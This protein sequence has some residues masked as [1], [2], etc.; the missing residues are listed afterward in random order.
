MICR[1][2]RRSFQRRF[3]RHFSLFWIMLCAFLLPLVVSTYRDSME[4]GARLQL[5][6]ISRGC[7]LHILN[8]APEDLELFRNIDGLTEPFYEDGTIYLSY[9]SEEFWKKST[10]LEILNSMS[11]EE[12][13]DYF[14]EDQRINAALHSAMDKS[15]RNLEI[16]GYAYDMWGEAI[17]YSPDTVAYMRKVLYLNVALVLFS[18]LIVYSAYGNHITGFSQEAAD[19]R[20]LGATEGQIIRLFLAEF[21]IIFPLAALGAIGLSGI[22]MRYLY[23]HFLGNT[24]DSVAMWEV[25]YMNPKTTALEILFY[26]LV[27]LCA[28][29][30][31]LMYRPRSR[32]YK[33]PRTQSVSLPFL[34]VHRTK[35]PIARCLLILA[36]L[37]TAFIL[38][39]NGYW[40]VNA[41]NTHSI[42][43]GLIV[44]MSGDSGF[45]PEELRIADELAGAGRVEQIKDITE[46]YLLVP[47]DGNSFMV[48]IHSYSDFA[49][50]SPPLE[51]YEIAADL[52]EGE[53]AL[54]VYH[55]E[56]SN[57]LGEQ[58]EVTL[59]RIV[60]T[61]NQDPWKVN[62]YISDA[63]MQK[64]MADAP[65]NILYVYSSAESAKALENALREHMPSAYRVNN[66]QNGIDVNAKRQEGRLLLMS[67][68]FSIL[69]LVAM[70]I[71]WVRLAAYVQSCAS[72]LKIL[73][74]VG[75]ARRQLLKLI[76]VWL[77]AASAVI[78]P[79]LI[80][81]PWIRM[82]ENR[83]F[84]VSGPVLCIYAVIA[85]FTVIIFWLPV[86]Y[87][88]HK[89]LENTK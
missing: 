44:V 39:F 16:V 41:Q 83:H 22:V 62:V 19:L 10:D 15:S 13:N 50:Q 88:L 8:A 42:V 45:S 86:K 73:F 67:W 70:Q 81:I 35:P 17:K 38:L 30:V 5:D 4:Y 14:A 68:I 52:P 82:Q 56:R 51:E 6:S 84:I 74:Q 23:E 20:A 1:Y 2:L 89:I 61:G 40:N 76:P 27:C 77:G 43:E 33:Q 37:V 65:V 26:F 69:M 31:S 34:W 75:G 55:L 11:D 24:A 87:T 72:M 25:F 54:G 32:K 48:Y 71:I 3:L 85:V 60:E 47:P 21:V 66:F 59:T 46:S 7:A 36:P 12:W 29:L 80:A 53:T 78:L 79:Y 49:P 63:L 64:L 28:L 9:E 57:H 18:G 58:I